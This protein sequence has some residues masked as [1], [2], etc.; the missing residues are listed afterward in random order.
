MKHINKLIFL[1]IVIVAYSCE[2]YEPVEPDFGNTYPS[3]VAIANTAT[4][5]VPEGGT[6]QVTLSSRTKIYEA[7]TVSWEL[8]GPYAASGTVDI[9]AGESSSDVSIPV[10]AGV[11]T[12][13][14]SIIDTLVITDAT[15]GMAVGRNGIGTTLEVNIT[16][17]V[18]FNADDYA[19][20]FDC[21]E[22]GYMV[23]PC[24]FIETADPLVLTNTNF[25]DWGWNVDYTFSGDFDQL[26]TIEE[27]VV[28]GLTISGS[29]SY[30]GLTKTMVVDYL[31]VDADGN[32]QDQNTHTFT[33]PSR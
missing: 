20:T 13:G 18:P 26:I 15:N 16:K 25:W 4:P 19:I 31:I 11:V 3:Y 10:E 23:Y 29:G 27:Q 21:D 33:V 30:D 8:I 32:I 6:I 2:V 17:F 5:V 7:Y 9:E 22:P 14:N 12:S 28:N 24:T 1:L